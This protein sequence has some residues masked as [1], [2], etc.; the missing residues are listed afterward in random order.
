MREAMFYEPLPDGAVRCLLCPR[1]CVVAPGSAGFCRVRVNRAGKLFAATPGRPAALQAD[2][3]EKKPLHWFLP[4]SRTFSVGTFGCNL[5]CR[6]CQND[7]LSR[8]GYP[9]GFPEEEAYPPE[10]IVELAKAHRSASIAFTYNEPTVFFEYALDI[11]RAARAAGLATVLVSNGWTD[12]AAARMLYPWIDAA[13]I[14]IKGFSEAFYRELC[15]GTLEPVKRNCVFFRKQCGGHLE[16]TNLVIPGRNDDP[17]QLE[18]YLDWV[19]SELGADTPLHFTAYFPAGGYRES[20]PTPPELLRRIRDR[21]E[22][23][24]FTRVRLGNIRNPD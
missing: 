14:D 5:G 16:L 24:G 12:P 10:R 13:N 8:R 1:R 9:E 6:F 4:G 23:R 11:A 2:P 20:P 17:A 7:S 15:D 3:I 22:T 18:A 19:E 21:A